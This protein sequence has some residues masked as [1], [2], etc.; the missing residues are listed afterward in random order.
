MRILLLL[1]LSF[2]WL[3]LFSQGDMFWYRVDFTDKNNNPYSLDRPEE[4]LSQAALDRRSNQG[5]L[6][7]S[8]DLPVIEAY[9]DSVLTVAGELVHRTKWLNGITVMVEPQDTIAFQ[10][11]SAFSFVQDISLVRIG[12][13]QK[14][15]DKFETEAEL[16][17]PIELE[18][19]A[20]D[21]GQGYRQVSMLQT[22]LLH[23]LGF[24]GAGLSIA[25]M[26]NGYRGIHLPPFDSMR[27]Q[28]RL[29]GYWDFVDGDSNVFDD[30]NHGTTVLSTIAVNEPGRM[31]GAAPHASFYL[32]NTED[33][34]SE[35]PL[36][37][38][39]WLRAAEYA[40][41]LGVQIFNT[42]LGYSTFDDPQ[43]NF[44]YDD[45]DGQSTRISK[46]A[47]I[48]SQKGILV[49]NSAGNEGNK[50]WFYITAPADAEGIISVAAVNG[51][52]EITN[53]S[54]RGPSSDNRI[55]P[56]LAAMG[57]GVTVVN[58]TGTYITSGGT[59]F[60]S[61]ILAGSAA[62]LWSAYPALSSE[63]IRQALFE[64]AHQYASPDSIYGF[65]I[66]NLYN[67]F[68]RIGATDSTLYKANSE[69]KV[70]PNPVVEGSKAYFGEIP[71]GTY[72]YRLFNTAGQLLQ[73]KS[74][75]L[76]AGN[77][78]ELEIDVDLLNDSGSYYIMLSGK[79]FRTIL[80]LLKQ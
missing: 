16:T 52:E 24:K 79:E 63:Q 4:F 69:I 56:E 44:S 31:I 23:S 14:R 28:G 26:D 35:S 9:V 38:D 25:I 8:T 21:Y 3:N 19:T 49:V 74:I 36:E 2:G 68:L 30:G 60:A 65:G 10:A 37:E 32:F 43:F 70:Y 55:K 59:S 45:L 40:D 71:E 75:D 1:I 41:S 11:V 58:Q 78:L 53:F 76:R 22:D 7:D 48:A 46:A 67:A 62:A 51:D 12:A 20:S 72:S 39:H 80:Q 42:S 57:S 73:K 13:G 34:L 54:S 50:S 64:S 47:S 33:N 6:L 61:P 27:L 77:Y 18:W 66:P 5:I 17:G 29:L 15:Q